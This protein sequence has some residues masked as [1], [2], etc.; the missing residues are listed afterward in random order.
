MNISEQKYPLPAKTKAA[1]KWSVA[2]P[3][4]LLILSLVSV[5][6]SAS[7]LTTYIMDELGTPQFF[8]VAILLLNLSMT[9]SSPIGGKLSDLFGRKNLALCGLV[10]FITAVLAC[11]LTNSIYLFLVSFF[12]MGFSYGLCSTMHNGM[13][14]DVFEGSDRVK[15]ISYLTSAQTL[16][17]M[18]APV[19]AGA[20]ADLFTPKTAL[21]MMGSLAVAAWLL[22]FF[23]YPNIRYQ[24]KSGR[25]DFPGIAGLVVMVAP[26]TL[27]LTLGG[28]QLSWSSPVTM[29]MLIV[30]IA[31]LLFF[32]KTEKKAEEPIIDFQL[33]RIKS[34]L[35]VALFTSFSL[36]AQLLALS[37]TIMYAQKVLGFTATETGSF[38]I[39]QIVSIVGA[40]VLGN[41]LSK[42]KDYRK[43]FGAAGILLLCFGLCMLLLMTPRI[44]YF[45]ILVF[46][47][48]Q[49]LA[50]ML[51]LTP[52]TA[53]MSLILPA[54]KRGVGMAFMGFAFYIMNTLGSAVFGLILNN[55]PGGIQVSFKYMAMVVTVLAVI[56][57][58]ILKFYIFNPEE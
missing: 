28:K 19:I 15:F 31:G 54:E 22:I 51:D 36:P 2:I 49:S 20:L 42:T 11:G 17:Q 35:P 40:P 58:V 55:I 18:L 6:L 43:S 39:L 29:G 14:A 13:I 38:G 1:L 5:R 33:F 32:V 50:L 25:I 30:S 45:P 10:P 52:N 9:I 46:M 16:A 23:F 4:T 41:W 26:F 12:I 44:T 8:A 53:M 21:M 3:P 56:R 47:L 48:L 7:N 57:I 37:Y 34:F 24:V 27:A